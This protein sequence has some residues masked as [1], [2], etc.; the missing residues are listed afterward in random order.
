[1]IEL[2]LTNISKM[3][4]EDPKVAIEDCFEEAPNTTPIDRLAFLMEAQFYQTELDRRRVAWAGGRPFEKVFRVPC[5]RRRRGQGFSLAGR[6]GRVSRLQAPV[7]T[8]LP[9]RAEQGSVAHSNHSPSS[10]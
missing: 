7:V 6:S 1:M 5:S 3:T 4:D 2:K 10:E 9:I 8:Q